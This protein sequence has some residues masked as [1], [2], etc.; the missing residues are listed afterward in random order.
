MKSRNLSPMLPATV[1]T[2]RRLALELTLGA[3]AVYLYQRGIAFWAAACVIALVW[4]S[5]RLSLT[6]I[7]LA[8][9]WSAIAWD[10]NS[11]LRYVFS[12]SRVL[13]HP[14]V[15]E[16]FARLQKNGK[17]P[18][19]N[20]TDWRSLLAESYSRKYKRD[21]SVCEARFNIKS[22]LLFRNA[23]VYF[24][25]HI[26]YEFEIPYRWTQTGEP[27]EPPS[28]T[29]IEGQLAVRVLLVNGMLLL[30]VG[31]FGREYSLKVY[32]RGYE[33]FVTLSSF[34]LIYFSSRHGIPVRYLN[35]IRAATPSYREWELQRGTA[36]KVD[37]FADW[38]ILQHDAALYLVLCDPEDA[39]NIGYRKLSKIQRYFEK[40]R[41][42]LLAAG[43]WQTSDKKNDFPG[44]PDFG[45]AYWN[46]Y[47]RVEFQNLNADRDAGKEDR[48]MTDYEGI[49]S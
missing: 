5:V 1:R 17:A 9:R 31:L 12:L 28:L 33:A 8:F 25:D 26:Y 27:Q 14:A 24:G 30:Q 37:P 3:L 20:L 22:N 46:H 13:E 21:D 40:K 35:L 23:E 19:A 45:D 49:D 6:Q 47:G 43:G 7:T 18:A 48:W 41:E 34:P 15:D 4:L 39:G 36:K 42:P 29:P 10:A 44:C 38:R 32:D 2:W 11:V 16:L